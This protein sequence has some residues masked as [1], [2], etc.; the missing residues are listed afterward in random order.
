MYSGP[1]ALDLV[2]DAEG[3]PLP[4]RPA[5]GGGGCGALLL[6]LA[7]LSPLAV[8]SPNLLSSASKSTQTKITFS[9]YS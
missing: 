9:Y 8:D 3:S 7:E 4:R 2:P 1:L 6:R 5:E